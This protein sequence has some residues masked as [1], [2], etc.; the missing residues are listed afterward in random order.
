MENRLHLLLM[1]A[2]KCDIAQLLGLVLELQGTRCLASSI[3]L[4]HEVARFDPPSPP[5][6]KLEVEEEQAIVPMKRAD[7]DGEE[8]DDGVYVNK[9]T[10]EVRGPRGP[11][12]TRYGDWERG[13]RCSD[14]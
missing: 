4:P 7:E 5:P 2:L 1:T 10:S 6:S 14:F 8:E 9:V 13:G 12:P 3:S 11:E